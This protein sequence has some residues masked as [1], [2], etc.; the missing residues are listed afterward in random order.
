MNKRKIGVE[1]ES[2]VTGPVA[3]TDLG[4][5]GERTTTGNRKGAASNQAAMGSAQ[6]EGKETFNVVQPLQS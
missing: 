5:G 1:C 4:W 6:H 3:K 2:G